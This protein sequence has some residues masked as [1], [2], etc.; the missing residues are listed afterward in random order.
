[1]PR[2]KSLDDLEEGNLWKHEDWQGDL[3]EDDELEIVDPCRTCGGEGR[4]L[5]AVCHACNGEGGVVDSFWEET[6]EEEP[7]RKI[8]YRRPWL[9][10]KQ[11][12]AIFTP[13]RYAVVEASTKTGKTVGCM[14]WLL[15]RAFAYPG[16]HWWVSPVY[17]QSK[18]VYRRMKRAV[19]KDLYVANETELT[20]TFPNGSMIF[21][22]TAEKPDN[23]FGED[24][25]SVVIDE[26]TRCREEAWFAIR[27]TLTHTRG[28]ARL[29]G[30]VKGKKNWAWKLA[31]R[32][33]AETKSGSG[34]DYHYAKLTAYDAVEAGILELAEI[35]DAERLL[36]EAVFRELY[37]A[38]ASEDGSNPFD[39]RAIRDCTVKELASGPEQTWGWDLARGRRPG[40][41]WTVGIGLNKQ[42]HV[43][44][45]WRFQAPW[46]EQIQ[47]I[48]YATK[49]VLALVDAT[50]VGDPIVEELQRNGR[51]EG[52]VFGT[53]SK[54]RLMEALSLEIQKRGIRFP[55]GPIT[56]ELETFEYEYTRTGVRYTAPA[57][58][59]DDCVMALALSNFKARPG[60]SGKLVVRVRGR[61]RKKEPI[62]EPEPV[63]APPKRPGPPKAKPDMKRYWGQE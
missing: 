44:G 59:H 60:T 57:G 40:S 18:M 35:E 48:T 46:R 4:L 2:A 12:D 56:D 1:M 25:L 58:L 5:A 9:Y 32:A 26:A 6:N 42:K 16:V 53:S 37:L 11:L 41:D 20:L 13:A 23:L 15:E 62:G 50:G 55:E 28:L 63:P 33:E 22:K 10:P 61:H 43:S 54:Q 36:P 19:P 29:I 7:G 52:Y 39:L 51:Y 38:E 31:R 17:A 30:N 24:V 3:W 14:V 21:F 27:S 49:R 34:V 8:T 45:F 47:R